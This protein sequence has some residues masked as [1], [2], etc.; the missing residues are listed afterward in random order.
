MADQ[1]LHMPREM[2]SLMG[3]FGVPRST[4]LSD[5]WDFFERPAAPLAAT[6]R[7]CRRLPAASRLGLLEAAEDPEGYTLTAE[8]PGFDKKDI[9]VSLLMK[10]HDLIC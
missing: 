5:P 2:D 8:V 3:A 1:M 6:R 10:L 7:A 9:K 4:L